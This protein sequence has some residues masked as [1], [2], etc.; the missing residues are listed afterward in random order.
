MESIS[1]TISNRY[2]NSPEFD[3]QLSA[4]ID[5]T[6]AAYTHEPTTA[7]IEYVDNSKVYDQA[8][9]QIIVPENIATLI[10]SKSFLPKHKKLIKMHGVKYFEKLAELAQTKDAPSHWYAKSTSIA[11]WESQ[12]LPMLEKLFAAIERATKA[13]EKLGLNMKWLHF[14]TKVAYRSTEAAFMGILEQ[15]MNSARTTPQYYFRFLATQI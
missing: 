10:D 13:I 6:L 7:K 11:K 12:T 2:G 1:Q 14:Y 8:T 9:Q 3:N 4:S 5:A 15:A